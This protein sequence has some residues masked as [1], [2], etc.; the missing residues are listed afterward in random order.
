MEILALQEGAPSVCPI[1][2]ITNDPCLKNLTELLEVAHNVLIAPDPR[3][4]PHEQADI[5]FGT[6]ETALAKDGFLGKSIRCVLES[7]D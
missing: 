7:P 5:D 6:F 1:V 3:H 2:L 4:L